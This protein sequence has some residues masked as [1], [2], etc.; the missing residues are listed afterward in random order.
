MAVIKRGD[1]PYHQ[2]RVIY[3]RDAAGNLI[4]IF[5]PK[6]TQV[7]ADWATYWKPLF[8][9]NSGKQT[10]RFCDSSVAGFEVYN[11]TSITS[12]HLDSGNAPLPTTLEVYETKLENETQTRGLIKIPNSYF[13][14]PVPT[15]VVEWVVKLILRTSRLSHCNLTSVEDEKAHRLAAD[16]TELFSHTLRNIAEGDRW[17]FG[18]SQYFQDRIL[19]FTSR[20]ARLDLVLPAFP[21]KSTSLN[22]VAGTRPDKGEE[23]ALRGLFAFVK[24]VEKIYPPGAR[25]FI[26]S[27]GHVFSDCIGVDDEVVDTY[28]AQ[29]IEMKDIIFG[30]EA[31][32]IQFFGLPQLMA[33]KS[34]EPPLT[35]VSRIELPNY[36]ETSHTG[37]G[38]LCRKL[39]TTG[40]GIDGSALRHKIDSGDRAALALYRGFSRFMLEDLSHNGFMLK[41]SKSK[42][43]RIAPKIAFEM[44]KRN[45]AYSNLCELLFPAYIRLSIHAHLNSGPKYGVDLLSRFNCRTTSDLVNWGPEAECT[46]DLLH[47]P[48]PWH[49]SIVKIHNHDG[50]LL[51]KAILVK[52]AEKSGQYTSSWVEGSIGSGGYFL[53]TSTAPAPAPPIPAAEAPATSPTADEK[54]RHATGLKLATNFFTPGP[55]IRRAT[56]GT[57][58]TPGS[59]MLSPTSPVAQAML[60]A[61]MADVMSTIPEA[62]EIVAEHH[63]ESEHDSSDEGSCTSSN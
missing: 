46:D 30:A 26:A 42:Q 35:Y 6:A 39:M 5:G 25:M 41:Q 10:V 51:V 52:D 50:W 3:T 1:S 7:E 27:D 53:L 59:F 32:K 12:E 63:S 29:L 22:K 23:L 13:G 37:D 47:V 17:D 20:R 28:S 58:R 45:Q 4:S 16:I 31:H 24:D 49:N 34:S 44:L 14:T 55:L 8:G 62:E 54:I 38:S 18:G 56:I 15:S 33:L 43:K 9:N 36:V 40:F 21:C 60:F 61:S 57:P 11:S 2:I 19:L 48:T